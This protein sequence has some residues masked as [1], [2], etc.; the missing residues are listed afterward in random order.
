MALI[1]VSFSIAGETQYARAFAALAREAADLREPL[2]EIGD[3]II[4]TVGKQFQTEGAH[5][6]AR[7]APLNPDYA[8]Y[9]ES[10]RP[11]RPLLV[12]DALMRQAALSRSALTVG[13]RSLVYEIRDEKAI[14][15][16][17]GHGNLPQRKLVEIPGHVRR[18]WDRSF[19]EWLNSIRR[20]PLWRAV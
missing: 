14:H 2:A 8:A 10:V 1:P 6:G 11:G 16:Q 18:E 12:F 5:G 15:H 17:Q 20:G 4:D 9:K 7:W 3:S 19:V 13:P